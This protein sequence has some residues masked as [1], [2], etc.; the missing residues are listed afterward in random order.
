[1]IEEVED[2]LKTYSEQESSLVQKAWVA[3]YKKNGSLPSHILLSTTDFHEAMAGIFKQSF[4]REYF[5]PYCLDVVKS[6][7]I[8]DGKPVAFDVSKLSHFQILNQQKQIK[9]GKRNKK[10]CTS[11]TN[12][13]TGLRNGR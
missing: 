11:S 7:T 5:T 1:M 2:F 4:E 10:S 13:R 8:E 9:H 6:G 3:Y 12:R